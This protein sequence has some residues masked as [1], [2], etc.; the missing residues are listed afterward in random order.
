MQ[1]S[2]DRSRLTMVMSAGATRTSGNTHGCLDLT[3]CICRALGWTVSWLLMY[4]SVKAFRMYSELPRPPDRTMCVYHSQ[5]TSTIK[6]IYLLSA[7]LGLPRAF[8]S[9]EGQ[10]TE[11]FDEVEYRTV[12]LYRH[13]CN[14][15]M[16][17]RS[18]VP[19]THL[20][21]ISPPP[22]IPA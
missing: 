15:S 17:R 8:C 3:I 14:I 12:P 16:L 21:I 20:V 7:R 22:R 13:F 18:L 9:S 2:L 5:S 10:P 11:T 19:A 4:L 1:E 6:T